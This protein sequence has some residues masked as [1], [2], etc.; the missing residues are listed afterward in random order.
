LFQFKLSALNEQIN[1]S[2]ICSRDSHKGTKEA[3]VKV[4]LSHQTKNQ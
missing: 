3:Q 1:E 4:P 2:T